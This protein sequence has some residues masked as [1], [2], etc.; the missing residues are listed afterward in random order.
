[1]LKTNKVIAPPG[2]LFE[3]PFFTINTQKALIK[4]QVAI[5]VETYD[6][7]KVLEIFESMYDQQ[8][9]TTPSQ[10]ENITQK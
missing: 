5:P 10:N 3:F 1:M 9:M 6:P 2:N 7:F 4:F 8:H